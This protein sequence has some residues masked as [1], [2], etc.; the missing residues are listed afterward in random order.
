M[1]NDLKIKVGDRLQSNDPRDDGK[2]IVVKAVY[3]E[4]TSKKYYAIYQAGVRK[5]KLRFDRIF[6]DGKKRRQGYS[7]IT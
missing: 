2:I 6:T 3:K 4:R 5:A 1:T 7:L